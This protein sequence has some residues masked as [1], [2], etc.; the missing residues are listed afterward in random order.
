MILDNVFLVFFSFIS[1]LLQLGLH[2]LK[3]YFLQIV[4]FYFHFIAF[5]IKQNY[6]HIVLL[7]SIS[8]YKNVSIIIRLIYSVSF[9]YGY[10]TFKKSHD[11]KTKGNISQLSPHNNLL[12]NKT[13]C[14]FDCM[15]QTICLIN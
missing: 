9:L 5:I 15:L 8:Y 11:S 6:E 14:L 10:I 4:F 12:C 3:M 13:A 1:A 7:H 2:I